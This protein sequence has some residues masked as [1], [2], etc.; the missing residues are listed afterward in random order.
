MTREDPVSSEPVERVADNAHIRE[1][2]LAFAEAM[3]KVL[4]AN[5]KG[6]GWKGVSAKSLLEALEEE[7]CELWTAI[8]NHWNENEE[9]E[10]ID[11]AAFA[12][13]IWDNV[14]RKMERAGEAKGAGDG[15]V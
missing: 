7:T 5:G 9:R 11:V 10:A 3:A 13:F 8:D 6:I 14:T 15:Q 12:M 2:C 4:I 1:C